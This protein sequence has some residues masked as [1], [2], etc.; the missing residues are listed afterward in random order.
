[1]LLDPGIF[2]SVS[3]TLGFES[4]HVR[5]ILARLAWNVVLMVV[6]LDLMWVA[7]L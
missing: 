2:V 3:I 5:D 6:G 7:L 4:Y 1:M